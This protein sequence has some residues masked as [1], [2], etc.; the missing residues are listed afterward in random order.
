MKQGMFHRIFSHEISAYCLLQ[1]PGIL[2]LEINFLL[3]KNL[4]V[5]WINCKRLLLNL[6]LSDI[7]K[8]SGDDQGWILGL[9][10]WHNATEAPGTEEWYPWE[11]RGQPSLPPPMSSV[12]PQL[13]RSIGILFKSG[14]LASFILKKKKRIPFKKYPAIHLN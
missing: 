2:S 5:K 13:L 14:P 6:V 12:W 7:T 3:I 4:L 8:A 1:M 9:R 11:A 10:V